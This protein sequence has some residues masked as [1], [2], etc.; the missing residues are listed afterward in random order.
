[1]ICCG[2]VVAL[3][4]EAMPPR[5][6]IGH[7]GSR[8]L[9]TRSSRERL[10]F[11]QRFLSSCHSV[12]EFFVGAEGAVGAFLFLKL[13]IYKCKFTPCRPMQCLFNRNAMYCQLGQLIQ[14]SQYGQFI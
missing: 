13:I 5:F 1:M 14:F 9:L 6:Y 8:F 2:Q 3:F 12:C 7:Q 11:A 4:L 10:L